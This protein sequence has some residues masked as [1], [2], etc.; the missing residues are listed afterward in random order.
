MKIKISKKFLISTYIILFII[1]FSIFFTFNSIQDVDR[2]YNFLIIATFFLNA[3]VILF[4]IVIDKYDFSL[5]K[6]FWYFSFYFFFL[7]PFFQYISGYDCWGYNIN[8]ATYIK[9]NLLLLLWFIVYS[10]V[11]FYKKSKFFNIKAPKIISEKRSVL[12]FLTVCSIFSLLFLIGNVGLN[13][14]FAKSSNFIT[15]GDSSISALLTGIIRSIPLYSVLYSIY[16]FSKHRKGIFYVFLLLIITFIVDFPQSISRYMIGFVY[17]AILLA[18]LRKKLT[19]RKF[20]IILI[21]IFSIVFPMFQIFKWYTFEQVLEK[22]SILIEN[23]SKSYNNVDFDAYSMFSRTINYTDSSGLKYGKQLS[24]SLFFIIPRKI[25][26]NKPQPTGLVV[27]EAQNQFFTNVSAPLVAE[28]YID[29]GIIGVIVYAIIVSIVITKMDL[30]YWNSSDYNNRSLF[31][32][33]PLFGVLIFLLR[34]S[35]QPVVVSAF[36]FYVFYLLLHFFVL[37][38]EDI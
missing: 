8:E 3:I 16:Y 19:S 1:F 14:M 32:Y 15:M 5:N 4:N 18:V 22:P 31:Y 17:I 24:S 29:F 38:K 27:A 12:N 35:M 10:Y 28:G 30:I 9:T 25:W 13:N 26:N 20:D 2:N 7:A 11:H 34:G 6:V 33:F 23:S 37:R 36:S 21:L